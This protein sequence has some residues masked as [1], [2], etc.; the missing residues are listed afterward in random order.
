MDDSDHN[1]QSS[2]PAVA[3]PG[4]VMRWAERPPTR[5]HSSRLPDRLRRASRHPAVAGSLATAAGLI[6]HA[7]L[8][9]ALTSQG[10]FAGL[11]GSAITP[12]PSAVTN[13]RSLVLFS[14]TVV[15]ETWTVRR[16]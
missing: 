6:L 4:P 10:R 13:G 14:R 5:W 2:L 15:V 9:W 8:R 1:G 11:A 12:T 3:I 7:G 16:R